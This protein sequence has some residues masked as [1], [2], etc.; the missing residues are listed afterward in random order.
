MD[1]TAQQKNTPPTQQGKTQPVQQPVQPASPASP[2]G[3][4]PQA[5]QTPISTPHKEFAPATQPQEFI[6]PSQPE[7]PV[8]KELQE[9]GVE[10]SKDTEQVQLSTEQK[11]VGLEAAKEATPVQT[12]PTGMVQLPPLP[13]TQDTALQVKKTRPVA[14]SIRWLAE[15]V[16]EQVKRA[17]KQVRKK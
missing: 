10:Q 6:K 5:P 12:T 3:Q 13:I 2:G 11:K 1:T 4:P 14:D 9:Y 17:H 7:V 8:S 15:L 16:L